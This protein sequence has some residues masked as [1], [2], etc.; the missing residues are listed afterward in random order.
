M[1]SNR[2]YRLGFS[3]L[4]LILLTI[5]C[6]FPREGTPTPSGPDM[7][8]TY[9]AQT[10]QAQLTL[11]AKDLQLTI[12]PGQPTETAIV[13]AEI[14]PTSPNGGT[15]TPAPTD[16]VCDR[17]DFEK[18]VTVP[19]NTVMAPDEE[20]TKTWRLRNTGI[21]TWDS[22]YAIVFDRGHGMEGSTSAVLT[23]GSVPP[24]ETVDVS[25]VLKAPQ[26]PGTYQGYWKLRNPVGQKFGLG[27]EGDKDFWVK[28]KVEPPS[29]IVYDFNINARSA[30]WVGSGGGSE[31][32]VP[33]NGAED[34][35]NGVAKLKDDFLLENGKLSG[36]ALVV[37][38][39]KTEDGKI[40]GTFPKYRIEDKDHFKAKL[41]FVEDCDGGQVIF[42]FG[43]DEAGN[44]EQ[45]GEWK[46]ACDGN[47]VFTDIDLSQ[48]KGR[49]VQ[50]VLI[51]LADGM[52]VNDLAVWGSARIE[53]EP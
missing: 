22:N 2:Y 21:C 26:D 8:R 50:F 28:I 42:Q 46:K 16:A 7:V 34:D 44:L 10:I 41:G 31:A 15:Q 38:P 20:F 14:T 33:F 11:M 39:K 29:G 37:G 3:L 32:E 19:D 52:L 25:V 6:N 1:Q 48:F 13:P 18:D 47:L 45:L 53:R 17:A 27:E 35:P 36:V 30:K 40:T 4:I 43:I 23:T 49:E 12:T 9:A 5:A 24:G 51:L